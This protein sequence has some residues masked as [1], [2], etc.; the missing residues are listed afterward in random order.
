MLH[1]AAIWNILSILEGLFSS[2]QVSEI[3]GQH[4]AWKLREMTH[5]EDPWNITEQGEEIDLDMI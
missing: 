2:E 1:L 5:S 4:S 3:F